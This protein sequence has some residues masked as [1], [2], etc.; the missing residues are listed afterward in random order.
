MVKE[1]I[2]RW[3]ED[4]ERLPSK[5]LFYRDG[6]S[7]SQYAAVREHEIRAVREA[8]KSVAQAKPKLN[9]LNKTDCQ[10]TFII[11]GKRHHTRFFPRNPQDQIARNNSNLKPGL[12]VDSVVT[13]GPVLLSDGKKIAATDFYLQSHQARQGTGRSAHYVVLQNEIQNANGQI[14]NNRQIQN[15]VSGSFLSSK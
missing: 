5:I 15:I 12:I 8:W 3:A 2:L 14:L 13:R 7:E 1:H 9:K 6:V 11:V 10:I 4:F